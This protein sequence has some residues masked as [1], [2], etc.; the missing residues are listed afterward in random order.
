MSE[1]NIDF[2]GFC[3]FLGWKK[4]CACDEVGTSLGKGEKYG[5]LKVR[6]NNSDIGMLLHIEYIVSVAFCFK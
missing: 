4:G 5:W 6:S 2:F 1:K 3:M